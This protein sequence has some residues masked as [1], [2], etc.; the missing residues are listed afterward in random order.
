MQLAIDAPLASGVEG[1]VGALGVLANKTAN[2][3][4]GTPASS[5]SAAAAASLLASIASGN[6]SFASLTAAYP[7]TLFSH[8]LLVRLGALLLM[9]EAM[10]AAAA[11]TAASGGFDIGALLGG[12]GGAGGTSASAAAAP[13]GFR[14]LVGGVATEDLPLQTL[15]Q[16]FGGE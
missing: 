16:G 3:G 11:S 12:G 13:P 5:D 1:V 9:Q 7:S 6:L 8:P 4:G 15:F 2:G 10:G 14:H